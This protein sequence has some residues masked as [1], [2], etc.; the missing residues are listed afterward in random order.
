MGWNDRHPN[1]EQIPG[2]GYHEYE[3][4]EANAEFDSEEAAYAAEIRAIEL[5]SNDPVT[6]GIQL[7]VLNAKRTLGLL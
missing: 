7:G 3:Q 1:A 5:A 6:Q 2:S 4:D